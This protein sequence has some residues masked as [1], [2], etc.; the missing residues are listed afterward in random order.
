MYQQIISA[1]T[2]VVNFTEDELFLFMK[3]FKPLEVPKNEFLLRPGQV[4]RAMVLIHRGALR[5]Y[6]ESEKGE[7]TQGFGF[8]LEWMGDYHSFLTRQP[9]DH[10]IQAM[11]DTEVFCLYYDDM[12]KLYGEGANFERFGRLIAEGLFL[13]TAAAKYDLLSLS[14]QQRYEKLLK[15]NPRIMQRV[16]QQ[17]VATY[18]GIAPQSLSRIRGK[19][20]SSKD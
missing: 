3:H 20:S 17:Y 15:L 9:S 13:A 6:N 18:L 12:Q 10:Y 11:E 19:L 7:K 5:Y 8:E 4:C 1:L 16:P 2:Q 14:A